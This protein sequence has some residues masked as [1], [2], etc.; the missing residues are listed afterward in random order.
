[1]DRP[2][3]S[4]VW[5]FRGVIRLPT[6]ADRLCNRSIKMSLHNVFPL[7]GEDDKC[8]GFARG[9]SPGSLSPRHQGEC[10]DWPL[11]AD[12][13][14]PSVPLTN[15]LLFY[16]QLVAPLHL[17]LNLFSTRNGLDN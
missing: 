12:V 13:I 7:A 6:A 15:C 10:Y 3:T 14:A 1:M 17:L 2:L 8:I 5:T 11:L 4:Q 9:R 16:S